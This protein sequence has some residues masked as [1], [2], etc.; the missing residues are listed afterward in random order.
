MT[1]TMRVLSEAQ[2]TQ[3]AEEGYL[4]VSGLIPPDV[5]AAAEA[6]MWRLLEADPADVTSWA[7][8]SPGHHVYEEPALLRCYTPEFLT[9]AAE[10]A[11]DDPSTFQPPRRA[12]TIN[13]FPQPGEW[14]WPSPHIDHAIRE[15]GHRTFPRAFRVATMT[16]LNDGLSHGAATVVWPGSHRRIEALARSDPERYEM[17][18]QLGKEIQKAG[19]G[20]PVELLARRGDVLFYHYL[21][22][23]AGSKNVS[24]HPRLAMN[25]KW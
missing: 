18:W 14:A 17:M 8:V 23:H 21:C 13:I 10:L 7:G 6:A 19:L 1:Q 24:A 3:Y 20:E 25:A 12:Y 22:A 15:H 9:A 5:A 2:L 4:L 11:G 16:Y